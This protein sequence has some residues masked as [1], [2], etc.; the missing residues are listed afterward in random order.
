MQP[1]LFSWPCQ[2]NSLWEGNCP[3][4]GSAA[5]SQIPTPFPAFP[6]S[7][8][9]P[10]IPT[11]PSLDEGLPR[12]SQLSQ[13]PAP[14]PTFLGPSQTAFGIWG[15][16]GFPPAWKIR[17]HPSPRS[18]DPPSSKHLPGFPF[19]SYLSQLS[20]LSSQFFPSFPSFSKQFLGMMNSPCGMRQAGHGAA[21]RLWKSGILLLQLFQAWIFPVLSSAPFQAS[22]RILWIPGKRRIF[23][24]RSR[25]GGSGFSG[26]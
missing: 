24:K 9:I 11:P 12:L 4:L 3:I 19:P 21:P 17:I 2:R 16:P 14:F 5:N 22:S 8:P 6:N 15:M 10:S 13:P 20:Q 25:L 7:H 1:E 26:G 18:R 23:G